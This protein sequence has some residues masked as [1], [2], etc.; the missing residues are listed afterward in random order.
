[1]SKILLCELRVRGEERAQR[2]EALQHAKLPVQEI[3]RLVPGLEGD[4]SA[5][6]KLNSWRLP[7]LIKIKSD[8]SQLYRRRFLQGNTRWK[9]LA[10]T[11]TMHS[12]APRSNLKIFVKNR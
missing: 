7:K 1:M 3:V 11:Y 6:S 2:G 8:R 10:E 9:A 4:A 5:L 12:F